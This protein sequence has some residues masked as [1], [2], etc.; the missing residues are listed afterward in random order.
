MKTAN[1]SSL[2][3]PL[4]NNQDSKIIPFF[5]KIFVLTL[6]AIVLSTGIVTFISIRKDS[7]FMLQNLLENKR[8]VL[9]YV[10]NGVQTAF[11]TQKWIFVEKQLDQTVQED[12]ILRVEVV[13]P[14][15]TIY[16]S[17]GVEIQPA[18]QSQQTA[19]S[20]MIQSS[21]TL[22]WVDKKIFC[23][24][25]DINIGNEFWRVVLY[26]TTVSI[27]HEIREMIKGSVLAA[28]LVILAGIYC[29]YFLSKK[30]T[31]P[32]SM[33]SRAAG[34][35]ARGR[36][37]GEVDIQSGDE[38]EKL[39]SSLNHMSRSLLHSEEEAAIHSRDLEK[40]V[41]ERIEE[42][43]KASSRLRTIIN[44]SQQG[45]WRFDKNYITVEINPKMT[46]ILGVY[47]DKLLGRS[48]FDFVDAENKKIF[49]EQLIKREK[50]EKSAYEMSLLRPD[51]TLIP[52][53]FNVTPL[54]S[55]ER[56]EGNGS[57]AMVTD[58]TSLKESEQKLL[59]AKE[60]AEAA[61][62]AKSEFL[63]NLSHEIRTPINGL[64]GMVRL[65]ASDTKL[66]GEQRYY[67]R[68][69]KISADFLYSLINDILDL[70][71]I[72]AQQL[73]L[74]ARPFAPERAVEETIRTLVGQ[75]KSKNIQLILLP[76][77][78]FPNAVK[79][80]SFRFRQ[81]LINLI[82]NAIK[83]TQE[84]EVTVKLESV[85]YFQ[86]R[87]RMNF[88]V[89]DTGVGIKLEKLKTIFG[90]FSQADSSVGREYGGTGLGLTI[91][92]NLC[93][94][95]DGDITVTSQLGKGS[96]FSFSVCFDAAE[97]GEIKKQL[98]ENRENKHVRPMKIL[99]VDDNLINIDL[100]R[101]V[102]KKGGHSVTCS[103]NGVEALKELAKVRF[104]VVLMDVQ[105]PIM[106]GLLATKVIRCCEQGERVK[107]K[108]GENLLEQLNNKLISKHTPIIAVTAHAMNE[109][110]Q[111]CLAAG[112][113][114]YITKPFQPEDVAEALF[115]VTQD[116]EIV[117]EGVDSTQEVQEP[118]TEPAQPS[119]PE[120]AQK[121]G[122]H[123]L[124]ESNLLMKVTSHLTTTYNLQ[125]KDVR[126]IL[127]TSSEAFVEN[128]A[129]LEK[130]AEENN[131]EELSK[132][133]HSMKGGLLNLGLDHLAELAKFIEL[134]AKDEEEKPYDD[135]V[136]LIDDSLTEF[137]EG[138]QG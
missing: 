55:D 35:I 76:G 116:S 34:E 3:K 25:K 51:N 15:G 26:G 57:F 19:S 52:C 30:I 80:D 53:Y 105:M 56:T 108:I 38:M 66:T 50:G 73:E 23:L 14:E 89:S 127:V 99:L 134:G 136:L 111:R 79:G 69:I 16:K 106:D 130:A 27:D 97:P 71:K 18:G 65:L 75:A 33:L 28:F 9:S 107:E 102:L 11:Y 49:D 32:I 135:L 43:K 123:S 46:E 5:W 113:D 115:R 119:A 133:A 7:D 131:F 122:S 121:V 70:S 36:F 61:N 110:K 109:D 63:A 137:I 82:N 85:H 95:M 74:E 112:M 20:A 126:H 60:R 40:I 67:L 124:P 94:L 37:G 83:F 84:G 120:P 31:R 88:V 98:I 13:S 118:D 100:A 45:F 48:I 22:M 24:K 129:I 44:T 91:C 62:L 1:S 42:L 6:S 128:L 92:K 47:A 101:I 90:S 68:T 132:A 78:D 72:E 87:Y 17:S 29:S 41:E 4:K 54:M 58:I 59:E 104:D 114:E 125:E 21:A 96:S 86:K 2:M 8:L 117:E 12:D 81:I 39:A 64:V 10:V 103:M 138:F 77:K 93:R